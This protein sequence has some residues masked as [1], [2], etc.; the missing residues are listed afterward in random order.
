MIKYCLSCSAGHE[1]ES[2]FRAIGDY[3]TQWQSGLI[4]CPICGSKEITKLPMAPAVLTGRGSESLPKPSSERPEID[5][6]EAA[7]L[8]TLR[9]FKQSVIENTEDVG[10]RFA[11]EARKIHFGEAKE[12]RIRGNS[13]AEEAK[14]MLEDG[15]PFGILPL[16][17]EDLN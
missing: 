5:H 8:G 15:V 6:A 11:D 1:F 3:D 14:E 12:R 7:A 4:V 10:S 13:T 16:L 17:P 2:W 9:A